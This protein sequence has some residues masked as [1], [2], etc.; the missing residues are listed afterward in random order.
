MTRWGWSEGARS[1]VAVFVRPTGIGRSRV[2]AL[3]S[4]G[5]PFVISKQE[6][7]EAFQAVRENKGAP[8]VDGVSIEEFETDLENNLYRVWNR[9]SSGTW[10]A[11]PVRAVQIPK[12][13]GGGMRMLGIPTVADRVAQTVAARHLQARVEPIF[14]PDSY[15]YRPTRSALQAV[16]VCRQR[17]WQKNWVVDIDLAQF[18][19]TVRWDLLVKAVRAHTDVYWVLLYVQRW[20]A[21]PVQLPD[22]T[23]AERDRGTPQGAPISPVLANLFLHYAF[24]RWMAERFP[25]IE[26]ERYADDIVVHCVTESQ[27]QMIRRVLGNRM[28][29]VG[30][31]LHPAKTRIVYC[32][33]GKRRGVHEH[34][35]FTFLGFTFRQR[36][37]VDSNG[38]SFSAFL[39][40]I[41]KHA[42]KRI[43]G[44]V[45]GWRLHRRIRHTLEELA[46]QI[47]PIVAGWMRYYG[48]F[49]HSALS[50]ALARINAYLMRWLQR[51]YRRLRGARK[52][53]QCWRGI[54][55]RCPRLFTHWTW[56]TGAAFI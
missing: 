38:Q 16:E 2:G 31:R 23:L 27:A 33:D 48:A 34:T 42:L 43:N 36:Q 5:K 18:F 39:P 41:S 46:E 4:S 24:D 13:H 55:T 51:K 25:T 9:M 40:A 8:G 37:A 56:T 53:F 35:S 52:A 11:A 26:F 45:R 1:S 19:D 15:G 21:A 29:E 50:P 30:L 44:I 47:N 54:T 3:R 12:P 22:G 14:H 28:A 17:C 10:F 20:L 6:V 32:K 7:W 49:Y